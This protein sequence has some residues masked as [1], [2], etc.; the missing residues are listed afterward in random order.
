M[1]HISSKNSGAKA[2]IKP[3]SQTLARNMLTL[4]VMAA[5]VEY[6]ATLLAEGSPPVPA[7]VNNTAVPGNTVYPSITVG[8]DQHLFF[9]TELGNPDLRQSQGS[10]VLMHVDNTVP[11]PI[12]TFPSF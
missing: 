12:Q 6:G 5:T 9:V 7:W 11:V 8:A 2:R 3:R 1:N 4:V 10:L